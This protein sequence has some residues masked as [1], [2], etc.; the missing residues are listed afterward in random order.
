MKSMFMNSSLTFSY[1]CACR[2][3][4]YPFMNLVTISAGTGAD[5]RA[6]GT[7]L[8]D[9]RDVHG[10]P[11]HVGH[12]LRP[13]PAAARAAGEDDLAEGQAGQL[14]DDVPVPA[15]HVGGGFLDG[16]DAGAAPEWTRPTRNCWKSATR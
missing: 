8:G 11:E 13:K 9:G 12:D 16:P 15:G 14:G 6:Q 5:G 2:R 10:H 3:S 4:D 7:A 1:H